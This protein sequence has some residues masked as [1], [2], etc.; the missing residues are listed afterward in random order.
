MIL[1][2]TWQQYLCQLQMFQLKVYFRKLRFILIVVSNYSGYYHYK[3]FYLCL[4]YPKDF[5]IIFKLAGSV[6]SAFCIQAETRR[7][8]SGLTN[9]AF[10]SRGIKRAA[11]LQSLIITDCYFTLSMFIL[12]YW[13]LQ[14]N[15]SLNY[16]QN[17]SS[18]YLCIFMWLLKYPLSLKCFPQTGH[19]AANSF[20]PR[21][22]DMWY[23]KLRNWENDL[24]HSSQV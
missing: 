14:A 13:T 3:F 24:W 20:V 1:P 17:I 12:E 10:Q 22:T 11:G 16:F 8:I 2:L 19:V 5:A 23:L 7:L 15:I 6:G 4:Y 21:W 18:A 9:P